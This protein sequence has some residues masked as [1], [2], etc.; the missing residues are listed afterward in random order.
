MGITGYS[1][2][3]HHNIVLR[4]RVRAICS[5]EFAARA[6]W[7]IRPGVET[8]CII[9]DP[10]F[11]SSPECPSV[12]LTPK[13]HALIDFSTHGC[14][15]TGGW[16]CE[17]RVAGVVDAPVRRL[18]WGEPTPAH[19]WGRL[20]SCGLHGLVTEW[21]LGRL[22]PA[23]SYDSHGGAAWS[24]ALHDGTSTL[25]VGCE[26]GGTTLYDTRGGDDGGEAAL[27]LRA[28]LPSQGSRVLSLAIDP[29]G[30]YASTGS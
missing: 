12:A 6:G 24:L 8:C 17:L 5:Q 29:A 2:V 16:H 22:S 21:D 13:L 26:D 11:V 10:I 20:F 15:R 1:S 4:A 3:P 19:P 30:A 7:P 27:R 18:A 23:A 28:R 9:A 25:A 14:G